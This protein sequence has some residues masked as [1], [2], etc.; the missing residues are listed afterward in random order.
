MKHRSKLSAAAFALAGFLIAGSIPAQAASDSPNA[1]EA[2][3]S[4][5][6]AL[7]LP[8][9]P[10]SLRSYA[11][12]VSI[13]LE[14]NPNFSAIELND[15]RTGVTIHWYGDSTELQPILDEVPDGFSVSVD[16]TTNRP[17]DLRNEAD[18][19]LNEGIVVGAGI[20]L[21]ATKIIATANPSAPQGRNLRSHSP[22]TVEYE[23][24]TAPEPASR[25]Q[26]SL[27]IG[28]ARIQI[29]GGGECSTAFGVKKGTATA[30]ITAAHC[31]S[32]GAT[33]KSGAVNYGKFGARNITHDAMLITGKSGGYTGG[34]YQND[35]YDLPNQDSYQMPVF[36]SVN[37][38]VNDEICYSGSFRGLTCGHIVKD[39]GY[40]WN[41]P[42]SGMSG[43]QG[44]RT[45][46]A[47]N[48]LFVG[49]GDS[50]GSGI[51][52]T[53]APGGVGV[54]P[55]AATI[56][57]GIQNGVDGYCDTGT[58]QDN[59]TCSAT[60]L[61]TGIRGAAQAFGYSVITN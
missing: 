4:Q 24:T 5:E 59:N 6:E 13:E 54:M 43:I 52:L 25:N 34:Y 30:M 21:D 49:K 41:F 31:G 36:G 32:T 18:R 46:Q 16:P 35:Q 45:K 58:Q 10:Q 56:I 61:T 1:P 37:P 39:V 47:S 19:L 22:F 26:D 60:V 38:I 50:G 27:G 53:K 7:V 11:E 12:D 15:L 20:D 3:D 29:S 48:Q 2:V 55:Y 28:G 17:G 42:D 23:E 57:S 44:F 51:V 14:G 40:K 33:V 9:V 8:I